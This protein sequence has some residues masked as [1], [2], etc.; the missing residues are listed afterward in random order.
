MRSSLAFAFDGKNEHAGATLCHKRL[1]GGGL[2]SSTVFH[3]YKV[4][5]LPKLTNA[6]SCHP[7]PKLPSFRSTE[8][9]HRRRVT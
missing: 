8:T 1:T 5:L 2:P 7:S 9:Q 6:R 3:S 4:F